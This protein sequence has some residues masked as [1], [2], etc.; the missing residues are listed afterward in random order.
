METNTRTIREFRWFWAWDDDKE[1]DW[2]REKSNQG[3][4][5]TK[6]CFPG[7][8]TFEEGLQKD[9][10]Y[11]LDYSPNIKKKDDYLNLFRDA[12]WVYLGSQN[13]WQYFRKEV[14]GSMEPEIFTDNESKTIK[15]KRIIS[16]L[17]AIL[18]LTVVNI[19]NL[20]HMSYRPVAVGLTVLMVVCFV[21]LLFGIGKMLKR[22]NEL[23]NL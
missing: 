16:L 9:Y 2:L 11:R 1:E 13:Y 22:I 5:L 18:P 7:I 3:F 21:F 6:V 14:T 17:A 15:Y 4:H 10:V 23:K 19:I 8:Y 12:G 20:S